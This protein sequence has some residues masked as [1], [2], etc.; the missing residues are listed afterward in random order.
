M[1]LLKAPNREVFGLLAFL[2]EFLVLVK[3]VLEQFCDYKEVLFVV[4]VVKE[5]QNV[6]LIHITIEVDIV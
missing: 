5:F 3:V 2:N 1:N 4:E 6:A